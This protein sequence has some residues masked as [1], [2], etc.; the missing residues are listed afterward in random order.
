M[1][2]STA[3]EQVFSIIHLIILCIFAIL[4]ILIVSIL[5]IVMYLLLMHVCL[6]CFP[7]R[8]IHHEKRV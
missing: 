8:A 4:T 1:T 6:K 2:Y 3:F 5:D 7:L